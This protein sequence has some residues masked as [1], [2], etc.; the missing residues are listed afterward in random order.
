[1]VNY[2]NVTPEKQLSA[3]NSGE[4][5]IHKNRQ[6]PIR[7]SAQISTRTRGGG[8]STATAMLIRTRHVETT[9]GERKLRSAAFS[10]N[11]FPS[12]ASRQRLEESMQHSADER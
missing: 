12:A 7:R 6:K 4:Q 1:M 2:H 3:R 10:N 9:R 11:V 8:D 5:K